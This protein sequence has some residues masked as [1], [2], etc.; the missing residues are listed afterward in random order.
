MAVAEVTPLERQQL[1]SRRA[2]QATY[3][4]RIRFGLVAADADRLGLDRIV[5][6]G[7]GAGLLGEWL[8]VERPSVGYAFTEP[9]AVLRAELLARFG[10]D[11]EV[12]ADEPIVAG[13]L[14]AILDVL[15]HIADDHAALTGLRARM[16]PGSALAITV[17]AMQWAFSSWDEE[18]GHVRRYSRR[19]LRDDLAAAG[20]TVR[21]VTYLFPEL[22]PLLLARRLR[23]RPRAQVD[24]P[25]LP[26]A[27]DAIGYGVARATTATRRVWPFGTSVV[28]LATPE[29]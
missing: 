9:S 12:G 14:V 8:T 19:R 24:F 13:T 20:F 5:D 27:L 18:L 28:A 23:R 7:A 25:E 22:F 2:A 4:H 1:E 11:R 3:W 10:V 15:E 21:S 29:P 16:A 26:T 6:F 17:P